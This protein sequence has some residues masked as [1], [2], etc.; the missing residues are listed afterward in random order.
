MS[1]PTIHVVDDDEGLR[2]SVV[3]LLESHGWNVKAYAN[4]AEFLSAER[5]VGPMCLILD[6]RMPGAD[7]L[8]LQSE[9]KR[10]G[11]EHSIIFLSGHGTIP[12][13]VKAMREGAVEFL[14]KP[15]TESDLIRAVDFA[16]KCE[17]VRFKAQ[18]EK[19]TLHVRY[20]KLTPREK[21]VF[22]YVASGLMNKVIAGDLG[23]SEIT[24]KVHRRRVME[25]LAIKKLADLVRI[26]SQLDIAL[27]S[28]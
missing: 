23:V 4:A 27:P 18:E 1:N 12:L 21:E 26:A 24:V 10:L 6:I 14:T 5:G 19:L 13:T 17:M 15:F 20:D 2:E 8:D 22:A 7:G 9:L 16:L 28:R 25:K 11:E 3:S